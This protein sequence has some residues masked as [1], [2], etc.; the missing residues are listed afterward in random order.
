M[1]CF[2]LNRVLHSHVCRSFCPGADAAVVVV[3]AVDAIAAV[4]AVAVVFAY[5][6]DAFAALVAAAVATADMLLSLLFSC[7]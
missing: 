5:V 3:A 2:L 4:A 7:C 6:V 1:F